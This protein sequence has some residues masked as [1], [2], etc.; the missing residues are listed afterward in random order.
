MIPKSSNRTT[1]RVKCDNALFGSFYMLFFEQ[2]N[3]KYLGYE[4][5]VK[6]ADY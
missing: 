4:Y 1:E 6:T 2:S 5:S 3:G